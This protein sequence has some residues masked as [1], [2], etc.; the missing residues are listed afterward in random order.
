M[1]INKELFHFIEESVTC[2]H[3]VENVKNTLLNAGYCELYENGGEVQPVPGGKYFLVRNDSAIIAFALPEEEIK[4]FHIIASHCDS[5]CFKLKEQPG[6]TVEEQY[7]KLNVE[8]YGGMILSTWLDRPLGVAGR[9]IVKEQGK[10]ITKLVNLGKDFCVIPN[11][12]IHF[13]REINKGY[14]YNPQVDMQP[15]FSGDKNCSIREKI[16][17]SAGVAAEDILGSDLF[18]YQGEAGHMI[19]A[20]QEYIL[21]PRLDDLQ[22]VFASMR[23]MLKAQPEK[24]ANVMVIFDNEEIGSRTRQGADSDFLKNV[25]QLIGKAYPKQEYV[26]ILADSFCISADN[27]HGLHPNHP[28]KSDVSNHP[29]LNQGI[30]L[31][32]HGSAQYTTDGYSAA[33]IRDLCKRTDIAMQT[34]ANR[35]DIAGGSTLGNIS[36]SQVSIPSADIGIAQLAMHSAM[37]TAGAE[38]TADMIAL[39]TAFMSE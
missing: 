23:G 34:Y 18:L 19:G 1:D 26:R 35:A 11:L 37:E 25:L 21:S 14:E 28:E 6:I 4:G 7:R 36:V 3:A 33:V 16:A 39:M 10:L 29:Y 5:P 17:K 27:A 30:V 24:Y 32:F 13:N 2:F 12:A 9:I 31:K 38:D 15:L 22:C 20:N 8:K